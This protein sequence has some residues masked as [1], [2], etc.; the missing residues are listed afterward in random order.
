MGFVFYTVG[1]ESKFPG[2]RHPHSI[3][4]HEGTVHLLK[5]GTVEIDFH[6]TWHA[7]MDSWHTDPLILCFHAISF[8]LI[9]LVFLI[10]SMDLVS[11]STLNAPGITITVND[12]G[13]ILC[14]LGGNSPVTQLEFDSNQRKLFPQLNML[15]VFLYF[16]TVRL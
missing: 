16:R 3:S 8:R 5:E 2:H 10:W 15:N 1:V 7:Y 13:F 11:L 12:V 9:T 6:I 4:N 14:Q